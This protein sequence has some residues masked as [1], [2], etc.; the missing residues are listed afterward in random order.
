M[1]ATAWSLDE[2]AVADGFGEF[3]PAETRVPAQT[4]SDLEADFQARLAV[5]RSRSEAAAYS[6]GRADGERAARA[7]VDEEI[8]SA[9]ALL[10][11]ALNNVQLHESRWVSN[12]EENIAAIA[13]MVARHIVQREVNA[14]PSFV[15]DVVQSAMAQYPLDQEITIRINPDDLNA[16]RA[17]IE[18]AGRREIRWISDASILRGGCLMEGRERIIDGRV[19][20]ALERAYRTLGGVQA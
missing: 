3:T 13:V 16:C 12:A 1:R 7:G 15:R 14:D 2:F 8:A 19:D 11:E 6:R 18:E 10:S 20:T 4:P 17:S 5:E 9:M